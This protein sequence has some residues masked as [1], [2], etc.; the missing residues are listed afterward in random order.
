MASSFSSFDFKVWNPNFEC[1]PG[2]CSAGHSTRTCLF[3]PNFDLPGQG[4]ITNCIISKRKH[5]LEEG[6]SMKSLHR[7]WFVQISDQDFG[8]SYEL[9]IKVQRKDYR[10]S[11]IDFFKFHCTFSVLHRMTTMIQWPSALCVKR[12]PGHRENNS[13][14]F[15]VPNKSAV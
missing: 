1:F 4:A 13:T 9:W 5:F 6:L 15:E 10:M 7:F 8:S 11:N 2:E 14:K 3:N 12:S